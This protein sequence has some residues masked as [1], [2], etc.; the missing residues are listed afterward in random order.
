MKA[1]IFSLTTVLGLFLATPAFANLDLAKKNNCMSC[2]AI[3]KKIVGPAYHDVAKKYAGDK[4]AVA[5]LAQRIKGGTAANGGQKWGVI[6]MPP[7]NVSEADA[8]TLAKWIL[9]GAK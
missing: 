6:P 4:N 9:D 3:D 2:H 8:Q 7:N 5:M 1:L